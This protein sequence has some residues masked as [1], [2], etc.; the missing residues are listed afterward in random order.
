MEEASQMK[1]E[2]VNQALEQKFI[3]DGARLVFWHDAKGEF[4]EYVAAGFEGA[5]AS[6]RILDVAEQGALAAKLCL[7][8]EDPNGKYLVYTEG[9]LPPPD[10]DWLLDI[11]LYSVEFS[12]DVANLWHQ[13]LGLASLSLREHLRER[14]AFMASQDR[15][16]R[17]AR[18]VV[19]SDD[20]AALDLKMLAVLS[21]STIASPFDVLT[22]I[23][24]S[25]TGGGRFDLANTPEV[26]LQI[27]KMGLSHCFW[28]LMRTEFSYE[29]D[30]PTLPGLMR[31]IFLSELLYEADDEG[32]GPIVHHKLPLAGTRN[33]V[34]FLTQ[35]RDSSTRCASYNL[36]ANAI[37]AEQNIAELLGAQATETLA[38]VFTFWEAE[39]RVLSGLKDQLLEAPA[40]VDLPAMKRIVS[41]RKAGHWLSGVGRDRADARAVADAYDAVLAAAELFKLA[42]EHR[43][44]FSFDNADLLLKAYAAE[45]HRYDRHYRAFCAMSRAAAGQGWDLLK[46]LAELVERVYDQAFLQPLGREWSRLLDQ[47][48]LSEWASATFPA[49]SDFYQK[50]VRP[51]LEEAD[52]RRAF[53]IIS[54]AFR[55]EAGRELLEEL[56][57]R[58]PVQVDLSAM[59]G[60]LP[61]YTAL[62]MASLL[63]HKN[64]AYSADG[65][66]LVDGFAVAGTDA[67]SKRLAEVEG[68]AVQAKEIREMRRDDARALVK[69]KRV[70][71][72]YHN[73]IDARG[74][75]A[76]TE[77]ET[78]EA[79]ADCINE[80]VELVQF[81]VNSLNASR[82]WITAD[83]GFLFQREAPDEADR[84]VLSHR[85]SQAVKSK[86]RYV[87]GPSLGEVDEAHHGRIS[88]TVGAEGEMEFWIP[89]GSNRFHFAGGARFVHGGAMPQEVLVPLLTVS[90]RADAE[91]R[92][93]LR[94]EKVS[95][96]VLGANHKITTPTYRFEIIQTEAVGERR[97][98]LTV[99]AAVYEGPQ[100]V[101]SVE[102]LTFDS[103]SSNI[104]ERK[105]SLRL[106]LRSGT[107]DKAKAYR[108]LLRDVE[109]DAEVQAIPV[110]IDRSFEDDF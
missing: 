48:F 91:A 30:Q 46:S 33:A 15:R 49:Q 36:A 29:T 42:R 106:E 44:G 65:E 5:L 59:L 108:L 86:K 6:V 76:S 71:Y 25:H 7:E 85:P 11:R 10:E 22:A 90:H 13:E 66:V 38:E 107:F 31:R 51:Y 47:G 9:Q 61:S 62:G 40:Q 43:S 63:P 8:R 34:V 68:L 81:C 102:A 105:K 21:G 94:S 95:I 75:S 67:R 92:S 1:A 99:R 87:I 37:A 100:P 70:I 2:Q 77:S 39:R 72:L 73:L 93:G 12:A 14:G 53:V 55:Y 52:R 18:L 57:A 54:D 109:T 83:H 32:F 104:D 16:R 24:D 98:P 19:P 35:W 58:C 89:R 45:L 88:D 20:E 74:D 26:F 41:A 96:Q 64:L 69:G 82:I 3:E 84:S 28:A 97:L 23:C 56:K 101:T 110:V 17:L 78:F 27:Q 103:V 79:V 4:R 80:L 60:V 50:K